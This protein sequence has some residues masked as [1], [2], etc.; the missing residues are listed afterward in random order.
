MTARGAV[1]FDACVRLVFQ[2]PSDGATLSVMTEPVPFVEI[3]V[4]P[5]VTTD[6]EVA[7]P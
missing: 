3:G 7:W 1:M 5:P 2:P 6:F 4:G